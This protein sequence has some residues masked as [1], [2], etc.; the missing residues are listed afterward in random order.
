[1]TRY[2]LILLVVLVVWPFLIFGLLFLMGRLETYVQRLDAST[3][4]EAG[5]E[6]VTG[7]SQEREVQ[8]VFGGQVVGEPEK[9]HADD[10]I[11]AH[12]EGS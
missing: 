4:E 2:Q 7:E 9:R 3:P 12:S 1:M 5:L 8:I 11:G 10:A 6:P